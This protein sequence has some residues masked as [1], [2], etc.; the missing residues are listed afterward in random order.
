MVRWLMFVI[1]QRHCP[2]AQQPCGRNLRVRI[3]TDRQVEP[4]LPSPCCQ[5]ADAPHQI[6]ALS[7]EPSP[8]VNSNMRYFKL[9]VLRHL[10]SLS[11]IA[12]GQQHFV[13][14]LFE[15]GYQS[16]KKRNMR[17]V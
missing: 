6:A 10:K 2:D 4:L 8:A 16:S 14:S 7:N 9:G 11:E 1:H 12:R 3:M 17:R 13:A 15:L 5:L